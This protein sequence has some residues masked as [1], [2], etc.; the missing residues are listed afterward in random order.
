[1]NESAAW[2]VL[3]RCIFLITTIV[4]VALL[5]RELR[6]V[7]V[8]LLL[9][10]LLASAATPIVDWLTQSDR[11]MRWRWRPARG[12][13]ALV[14]FLGAVLLLVLGAVAIVGTVA[15]DANALATSLPEYAIKLQATIDDLVARNPDLASA[16]SGALPSVRDL[17]G[18]AVGLAGQASRL[19][20]FAT[21][22]FGGVL[23]LLF[24]LI[25][26]LYLTIDGERIRRYLIGFLPADRH[27]Q[28]LLI[29]ER[30]GA[31]LGAWARGEAV[32]GAIIGGVT[33]VGALLLG[34]PYAS[35]L[36]LIA[37]VGELVPNLGPI[38][39]AVPLVLVGLL[40]SP[41]HGLLALV[42]AV[43]IQQLE[44]NLIVPRVMSQAVNLHPIAVMLA[45]L[46]GNELLGIPGALLAVPVVASL[47]VIVDEIQRERL[48]RTSGMD[49]N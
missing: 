22:L 13:A 47:S 48:A 43:V 29:T 30:I 21:G 5:M 44:N 9:A 32:L 10:V 15:P 45:I 19:V 12:V 37:G 23:Y 1:M 6:A 34:L 3:A 7:V 40:V 20:G 49:P 8:Q 39:A 26:A 14:V 33:W 28:A 46:S 27:D 18:G 36:A 17:L 4:L 25:L 42:L 38:I 16:V 35:A 24:S 2:R 41:T 31:R 11:A